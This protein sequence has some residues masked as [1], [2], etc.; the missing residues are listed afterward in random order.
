MNYDVVRKYLEVGASNGN[1][2]MDVLV[3]GE[4]NRW[5]KKFM[6]NK[7]DVLLDLL[8]RESFSYTISEYNNMKS[9]IM[10]ELEDKRH[11]EARQILVLS[12]FHKRLKTDSL[13]KNTLCNRALR[14]LDILDGEKQLGRLTSMITYD[15][16]VYSESGNKKLV[17]D[18][19]TALTLLRSSTRNCDISDE[20]LKNLDDLIT[21]MNKLESN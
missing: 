21:N 18:L 7:K 2:L 3:C 11:F 19:K 17:H 10:M 4:L 13:F 9:I 5:N 15:L 14:G 12:Y 6:Y 20:I 1:G 16:N 8:R